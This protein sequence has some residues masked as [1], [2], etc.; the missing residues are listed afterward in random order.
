LDIPTLFVIGS[1]EIVVAHI[2]IAATKR[3]ALVVAEHFI[4]TVHGPL[5]RCNHF[6]IFTELFR[7]GWVLQLFIPLVTLAPPG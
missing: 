3:M 4:Y 6:S 5:L 2:L 1:H 7:V